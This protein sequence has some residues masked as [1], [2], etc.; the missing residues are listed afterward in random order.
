MGIC[1]Q[2]LQVEIQTKKSSNLGYQSTH[3]ILFP[4]IP[5]AM[6]IMPHP[7]SPPAKEKIKKNG[8]K[9]KKLIKTK[10]NPKK[11]PRTRIKARLECRIK[12]FADFAAST[13]RCV[14]ADA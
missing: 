7:R 1:K 14:C 9:K 5:F 6:L 12:K 8:G 11:A 10:I 13:M 3:I 2:S 4:S